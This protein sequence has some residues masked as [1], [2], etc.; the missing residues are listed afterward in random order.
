MNGPR[1]CK[2]GFEIGPELFN[3]QCYGAWELPWFF[4][5]CGLWAVLYV[6]IIRNSLKY[7]FIEMPMIALAASISWEFIWAWFYKT[8]MG[9][10]AQFTY[11][12]WFV[13]DI[14]LFVL[15]WLYGHK[16]GWAEAIRKNFR[17]ALVFSVACWILFFFTYPVSDSNQFAYP[18]RYRTDHYIGA[19]TAYVDNLV[20]SAAYIF[21]LAR[22]RDVRAMSPWVAWLKGIGTGLNT[23][24]MF[25][26]FTKDYL[27]QSMGLVVLILDLVYILW[28]RERRKAQAAGIEGV[29]RLDS[30]EPVEVQ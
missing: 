24:F 23:V 17:P 2:D 21:Q 8:N 15:L 16:Q 19:I 28:L 7:K 13:V 5:G 14:G 4:V 10:L 25:I 3:L 26:V 20:I 1:I 18:G 22:M 12:L 11:R 9:H 27:L 30:L 6:I 29:P